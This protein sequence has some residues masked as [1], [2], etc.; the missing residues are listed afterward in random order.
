MG[1]MG[2]KGFYG[3]GIR[4]TSSVFILL[5]HLELSRSLG[6]QHGPA[7]RTHKPKSR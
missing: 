3:L 7:P 5:N 4:V 6:Y 1:F 2:S